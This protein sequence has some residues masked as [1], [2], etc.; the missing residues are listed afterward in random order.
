MLKRAWFLI[1]ALWALVF[2]WNGSTR[3]AAMKSGD[4]ALA[5]APLIIGWLLV[6]AARFVVTGSPLRPQDP[7]RYRKPRPLKRW[8][9]RCERASSWLNMNHGARFDHGL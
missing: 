1:A 4:I 5:L 6:P 7:V 3:D 8:F 9:S 2:L